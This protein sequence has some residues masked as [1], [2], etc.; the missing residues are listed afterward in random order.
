M[1]VISEG[2]WVSGCI[3]ISDYILIGS[4]MGVDFFLQ[5]ENQLDSV[6]LGGSPAFH[7]VPVSVSFPFPHFCLCSLLSFHSPPNPELPSAS[8][9]L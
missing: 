1:M 5:E 7:L 6:K 3:L 2:G 8:F 9:F 4:L